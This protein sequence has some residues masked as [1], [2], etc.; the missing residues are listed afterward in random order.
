M[1]KIG[2]LATL[3]VLL[4]AGVLGASLIPASSQ[5]DSTIKVYERQGTG[6][7]KYINTDGKA[8]L[9]GDYFV[10]SHP[11]YRTGTKKKV[12][13]NI[14]NLTVVQPLGKNNARFRAA[15]TFVLGAGKIEVAGASSISRLGKG[16]VFT[17]TGGTG[18]YAGATGTLNVREGKRRT[19][20]TFTLD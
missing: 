17:I 3:A 19:F 9:G 1:R 20:F 4:G 12:G 11:L 2:L 15:A 10:G 16:A 7:D 13:R 8:K 5:E 14:T 18:A 6:H